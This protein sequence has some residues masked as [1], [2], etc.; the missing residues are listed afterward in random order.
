MGFTTMPITLTEA[1]K[2]LIDRD[3]EVVSASKEEYFDNMKWL[4]DVVKTEIK[5]DGITLFF[6]LHNQDFVEYCCVRS[7]DMTAPKEDSTCTTEEDMAL[8]EGDK[9]DGM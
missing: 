2:L 5:D 6:T 8:Q 1:T 4:H 9:E 3:G 7:V